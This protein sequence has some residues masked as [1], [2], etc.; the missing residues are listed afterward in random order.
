MADAIRCACESFNSVVEYLVTLRICEVRHLLEFLGVAHAEVLVG[1]VLFVLMQFTKFTV[2]LLLAV[3]LAYGIFYLWETFFPE[4]SQLGRR[5]MKMFRNVRTS[6]NL[7]PFAS[8]TEETPGEYTLSSK[9]QQYT[10]GIM[11]PPNTMNMP[12]LL[13]LL[14]TNNRVMRT[15]SMQTGRH[16]REEENRRGSRGHQSFHRETQEAGKHRQERPYWRAVSPEPEREHRSSRRT[17]RGGGGSGESKKMTNVPRVPNATSGVVDTRTLTSVTSDQLKRLHNITSGESRRASKGASGANESKKLHNI[18]S[19]EIHQS[20]RMQPITSNTNESRRLQNVTSGEIK[21]SR[22]L[23]NITSNTNEPRRLR[24][25]TSSEMKESRRSSHPHG[26]GESRRNSNSQ[27]DGGGGESR[28]RRIAEKSNPLQGRRP[29]EHSRHRRSNN[30][31]SGVTRR[32]F[33]EDH[34]DRLRN[35]NRE[36]QAR[37]LQASGAAGFHHSISN[38]TSEGASLTKQDNFIAGHRQSDRRESQRN[39]KSNNPGKD[40]GHRHGPRRMVN[41]IL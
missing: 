13:P 34:Y 2:V 38:P 25:I 41:P 27:R 30:G 18:T 35:E 28:N 8:D 14:E 31:H 23:Q 22:R 3:F 33:P 17:S 12:M 24:N 37:R 19:G 29:E 4:I 10:S 9:V 39:P 36:Y 40:A 5:S 20:R 16:R 1:V 21:D 32:Q 26:G 15:T 11:T 7:P 6:A